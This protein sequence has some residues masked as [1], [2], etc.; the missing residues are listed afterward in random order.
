MKN[1]IS[2]QKRL[3][4]DQITAGNTLAHSWLFAILRAGAWVKG[5]KK[6][7]HTLVLSAGQQKPSVISMLIVLHPACGPSGGCSPSTAANV[8]LQSSAAIVVVSECPKSLRRPQ[9]CFHQSGRIRMC[10]SLSPFGPERLPP[11]WK[12][13]TLKPVN[14]ASA[15]IR[16]TSSS[17]SRRWIAASGL[18]HS[19]QSS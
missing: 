14:A 15:E 9:L 11:A 19:S 18:Y 1:I 5:R 2:H 8:I 4:S 10:S 6:A 7:A 3:S 16:S 13:L 12:K 17:Q